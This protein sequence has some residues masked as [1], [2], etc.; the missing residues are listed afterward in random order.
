VQRS[1]GRRLTITQNLTTQIRSGRGTMTVR[2]MISTPDT[3]HK[4]RSVPLFGL[5]AVPPS[6]LQ[7]I[8]AVA[9][10]GRRRLVLDGRKHDRSLN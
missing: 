10:I 8:D 4:P 3:T 6:R 1:L 5:S 7:I 9:R 2:A